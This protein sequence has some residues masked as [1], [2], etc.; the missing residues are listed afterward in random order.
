LDRE[1]IVSLRDT[2]VHNYTS[3]ITGVN[4][5][6][7]G[8]AR[9]ADPSRHTSRPPPDAVALFHGEDPVH[10][11]V[12]QTTDPR[13]FVAIGDGFAHSYVVDLAPEALQPLSTRAGGATS[14]FRL[15]PLAF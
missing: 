8:S 5:C 1:F 2:T 15:S 6:P 9:P 3:D 11:K 7:G 12:S 13:I 4:S 10:W 14:L